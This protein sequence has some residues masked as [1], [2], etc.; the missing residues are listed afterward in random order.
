M[1]VNVDAHW[2]RGRSSS[3]TRPFAGAA[4]RTF[5][6]GAAK[7]ARLS[8]TPLLLGLPLVSADGCAV[9]MRLLGPFRPGGTVSEQ[10]DGDAMRQVLDAIE[11]EVGE[12]PCEY[13]LD[14]GGERR[15]NPQQQ[16]W[17]D[18]PLPAPA[19]SLTVDPG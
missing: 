3:L 11:R 17:D 13:L 18:A 10:Q 9:R 8:G 16:R 12:R 14:I 2:S 1:T 4:H 15:W 7:L 19:T 5:S 6:T